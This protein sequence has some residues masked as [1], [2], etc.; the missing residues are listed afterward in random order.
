VDFRGIADNYFLKH[1]RIQFLKLQSNYQ[2]TRLEQKPNLNA[3]EAGE[4]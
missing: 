3:S 1:A 4:M 2:Y